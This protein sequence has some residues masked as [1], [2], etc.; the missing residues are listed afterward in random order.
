MVILIA[1]RSDRRQRIPRREGHEAGQDVVF[2]CSQVCRVEED[3]RLY[4]QHVRRVPSPLNRSLATTE[5]WMAALR[6]THDVELVTD[7][8]ELHRRTVVLLPASG[9]KVRIQQRPASGVKPKIQQRHPGYWQISPWRAR[10]TACKLVDPHANHP[11]CRP[12]S[13]QLRYGL[14]LW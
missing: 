6:I 1:V 13:L 4:Y 8:S 7:A 5:G 14:G 10:E 12:V 2:G 3:L 9:V 11:A